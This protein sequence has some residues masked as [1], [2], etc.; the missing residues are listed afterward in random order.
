M[1]GKSPLSLG[2]GGRYSATGWGTGGRVRDSTDSSD[3]F[4]SCWVTD[5]WARS[6]SREREELVDRSELEKEGSLRG[7][8]RPT[9]LL[10]FFTSQSATPWTAS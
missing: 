8:P 7:R 9:P 6:S 2:C 5:S 4:S 1:P 3:D 10:T